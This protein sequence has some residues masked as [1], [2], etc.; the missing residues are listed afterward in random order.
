MRL[1]RVARELTSTGLP[2][3]DALAVALQ[4]WMRRYAPSTVSSMVETARAIQFYRESPAA[5]VFRA[6]ARASGAAPT[7][8]PS[9]TVRGIAERIRKDSSEAADAVLLALVSG[10]ARYRSVRELRWG[11]VENDR[12]TLRWTKT[13]KKQRPSYFRVPD[14]AWV[15]RRLRKYVRRA[16]QGPWAARP[17]LFYVKDTQMAAVAPPRALRR[18]VATELVETS[19]LE[20]AA[21]ALGNSARTVA[22]HYAAA[23]SAGAARW[24]GRL[25]ESL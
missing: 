3:P 19:G 2:F 6:A 11:D 5:I 14:V 25:C 13:N 21:Q 8:A 12:I 18:A 23:P 15:R 9:L 1:R 7:P 22:A 24:A 10:G 16:P 20:M 17:K 4:R